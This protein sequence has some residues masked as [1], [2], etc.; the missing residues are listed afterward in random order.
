MHL[1]CLMHLSY[2]KSMLMCLPWLHLHSLQSSLNYGAKVAS[3]QQAEI[4]EYIPI[5][6]ESY[7]TGFLFLKQFCRHMPQLTA[8]TQ[9]ATERSVIQSK[10]QLHG[11]TMGQLWHLGSVLQL[12]RVL[13][14]HPIGPS[15]WD[16]HPLHSNTVDLHN[17][18]FQTVLIALCCLL[19]RQQCIQCF[20]IKYRHADLHT[21]VL[22]TY[23]QKIQF[24]SH[25]CAAN[26]LTFLQ[27]RCLANL[28]LDVYIILVK[29]RSH[30]AQ[31]LLP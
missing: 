17:K 26:F 16:S 11:L 18:H 28:C 13:P 25:E 30:C 21:Y 8:P 24:D 19:I 12:R 3:N 5:V 29:L 23:I 10:N 9:H 4:F 14:T 27:K 15:L 2:C 31:R 1:F 6:C 22:R 20:C 7:C